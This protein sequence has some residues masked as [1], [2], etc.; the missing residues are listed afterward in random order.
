[1]MESK[2]VQQ[3]IQLYKLE[4]NLIADHNGIILEQC[5]KAY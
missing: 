2:K 1:M 3:E 5:S 4:Q